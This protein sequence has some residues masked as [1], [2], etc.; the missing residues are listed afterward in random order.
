MLSLA[1][2]I[3][4]GITGDEGLKLVPWESLFEGDRPTWR[5]IK[6]GEHLRVQYVPDDLIH[7][8][9]D[10]IMAHL[11]QEVFR[12]VYS[13]P[14]HIDPK[15]KSSDLFQTLY[16]TLETG[17]VVQK[18]LQERPGLGG[19]FE[20]FNQEQYRDPGS[21]E[22][23]R[24]MAD[25]PSYLQFLE[26]ALYESR[27]GSED[28]RIQDQSVLEA[29]RQTR[30]SRQTIATASPGDAYEMIREIW[31]TLEKLYKESEDSAVSQEL[32]DES[33]QDGKGGSDKEQNSAAGKG[34]SK[35]GDMD[36]QRREQMRQE[37]EKA[38]SGMSPQQQEELRNRARQRMRRQ[39]QAFRKTLGKS[40]G[41]SQPNPQDNGL[42]RSLEQAASRLADK[43][44]EAKAQAQ[45]LEEKA[46]QIRAQTGARDIKPEDANDM[47]G[48]AAQ[49]RQKASQLNEGAQEFRDMAQQLKNG[50]SSEAAEKTLQQAQ[51]L[52]QMGKD[53][54]EKSRQLQE[55]TQAF[56]KQLGQGQEQETS[57]LRQKAA[58]IEEAA[59]DISDKAGNIQEQAHE[60]QSLAQALNQMM[61][62]SRNASNPKSDGTS[63]S[64][65][66]SQSSAETPS[67]PDLL[68]QLLQEWS[69]L[70]SGA[71]FGESGNSSESQGADSS[72]SGD[73][74][75]SRGK[76]GNPGGS[77]SSGGRGSGEA[78]GQAREAIRRIKS[79]GLDAEQRTFL[80][81]FLYPFRGVIDT[82]ASKIIK[83]V[84]DNALG[85]SLTGLSS[86]DVDEDALP[87]YKAR[88][89]GIMKEDLL[90]G[91]RKVRLTILIDLSGSMRSLDSPADTLY[92]ACRALAL[93]LKV[94]ARAFKNQP[95]VE[96][97]VSAYHALANVPLLAYTQARLLTDAVIFNLIKDIDGAQ[98]GLGTA[99]IETMRA[100]AEDIHRDMKMHPDT[101][102][103][104]L[105]IGDGNPDNPNVASAIAAIYEDPANAKIRFG[106]LAAGPDAEK[107]FIDYRPHS[108]WAKSLAELGAVWAE[109][110]EAVFKKAWR[111]NS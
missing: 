103:A 26:G 5:L 50:A 16:D 95:G 32:S 46:S 15:L 80:D 57:S 40:Q 38:L 35:P 96:V 58:G 102:Y 39:E 101:N 63:P 79:G 65:A 51:A 108:F 99:D 30:P 61:K 110:F 91:R 78:A 31:P 90:P 84:K 109:M 44:G 8:N 97:R 28:P 20:A 111:T 6:E 81:T 52:E 47:E 34:Q 4:R 77:Q 106:N 24:K 56:E 94:M 54:Q 66:Q 100:V 43:A 14:D 98:R 64:E 60:A 10:V 73:S 67:S 53:L 23:A 85:R 70:K 36:N 42:S 1:E 74:K 69:R 75:D 41:G 25:M 45:H 105:H 18:G 62:G 87:Y 27:K 86:G 71:D 93:G 104:V 19:N 37:L 59:K 48:Q 17:R 76:P 7:D 107:M 13:R 2:R 12:A 22:A 9:Q 92:Y 83:C 72:K 88:G 55:R 11:M 21:P 68:E 33:G 3:A 49:L 82:L 89:V 29:L